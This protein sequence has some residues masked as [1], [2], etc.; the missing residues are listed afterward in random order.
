M[1]FKNHKNSYGFTLI[2]MLVATAIFTVVMVS[3]VGALISIIN[4]NS[5]AQSIKTVIDN[6]TFAVDDMARNL[7]SGTNYQCYD[8]SGN[9]KSDCSSVSPEIGYELNNNQIY[10][11]FFQSQSLSAGQ[12]NIETCSVSNCNIQSGNWQSLTAP[13]S[14]VNITNMK[15]IIYNSGSVQPRI[16]ITATGLIPVKN[17]TSTEFDIQ[18]TVSQRIR[19]G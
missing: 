4:A 9:L 5:R 19:Q 13:T 18:T 15:F 2:E 11:R 12:G 1:A 3:A 10:Y 14:T 7:R 16:F 17:G 8:N 6:V